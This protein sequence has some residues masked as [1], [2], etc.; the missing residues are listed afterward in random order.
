MLCRDTDTVVRYVLLVDDFYVVFDRP[1]C[2][3]S[4]EVE[5]VQI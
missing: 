5:F 1:Q 3:S 4:N 2:L